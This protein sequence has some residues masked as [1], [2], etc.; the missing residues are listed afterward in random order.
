MDLRNFRKF[1]VL[2]R[3]LK[4]KN[5]GFTAAIKFKSQNIPKHTFNAAVK[6][7]RLS[8]PACSTP[9]GITVTNADK[10]CSYYFLII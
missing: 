7:S 2:L 10:F 6:L 1:W 3:H 9:Q 4:L 5:F 8:F